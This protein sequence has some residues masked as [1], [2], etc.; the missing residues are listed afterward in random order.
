MQL[1]LARVNYCSHKFVSFLSIK[2]SIG[3]RWK[4]KT[5]LEDLRLIEHDVGFIPN[6]FFVLKMI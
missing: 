3:A 1:L 2:I 6:M 4:Q 5:N